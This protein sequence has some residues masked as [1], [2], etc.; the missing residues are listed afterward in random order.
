MVN[1][2]YAQ[3]NS[4]PASMFSCV[5]GALEDILVHNRGVHHALVTHWLYDS[6]ARAGSDL[7]IVHLNEGTKVI[8]WVDFPDRPWGEAPPVCFCEEPAD[9]RGRS[10]RW[11]LDSWDS[12]DIA[13]ASQVILVCSW[14][15]NKVEVRPKTKTL[16]KLKRISAFLYMEV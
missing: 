11:M 10:R 9:S 13:T 14:C 12:R 7:V 1:F 16:P 4:R 8:K 5:A 3:G 6:A 2:S 15:Q